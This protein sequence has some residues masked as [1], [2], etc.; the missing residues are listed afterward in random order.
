M[1]I[2]IDISQIVYK[3]TGVARFTEGLIKAVCQFD[4]K[5]EWVFFFSSL[6]QT[7]DPSTEKLIESKGWKLIKMKIPPRAL[8]VIWNDL[9]VLKVESTMGKLDWFISSD[10]TEPPSKCKKA[11]I[12]HDLVY[13]RYPKTVDKLILKTQTKRLSWVKKESDLIFADSETTKNDL[14]ELL[15][16]E[17]K[18]VKVNYPGIESVRSNNKLNKHSLFILTVGKIEPRK[19]I[20]RLIEAFEKWDP[21]NIDLLIVGPEGWDQKVKSSTKIKWLGYVPDDKLR[22]LYSSC[23]FFVYPSIWEGFGYPI[24]EAMNFGAPV[25]ASNT[26]SLK[27][28]GKDSALLFDPFKINSIAEALKKM[29]TNSALRGDLARKGMARAK[30]FTWRRYYDVMI[31][32]LW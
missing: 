9:H 25:A 31:D 3:G 20:G 7:L 8:S 13:L 24:L 15:Q 19:N 14:I 30:E 11:A 17:N 6:R 4:R 12:V 1:K 29:A 21:K 2:G 16:I 22:S 27:E 18:K 26:S 23:L 10:W 32:A 5:N 28:I